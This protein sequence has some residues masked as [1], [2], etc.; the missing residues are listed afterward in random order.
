MKTILYKISAALVVL[1]LITASCKDL[2]EM[3]INPNGVDPAIAHPNLLIATVI[4][5]SGQNVVALGFGDMAGVMQHT[6]KDGWGGS[7]DGYEWTDQ[8]WSGY[9]GILRNTEA[10]IKKSKERDL[11]FQRA[12][13]LI[14][15]AYNFGTIADLWGDAPYSKALLGEQGG[16]NLK[17]VFDSQK[18]IYL[19]I[20]ATLDTA[21]TLL[22]KQQ[23]EYKDINP[24][25]DVM[26]NGD[27]RQWQKFANSI[28]LRYYLR[29]SSKEPALAQA[30]IEKIALYPDTY[31]L[32]LDAGDDAA[33]PFIGNSSSDSWPSNTTYDNSESNYRRLKMCSTL[34]NKLKALGD[35][36]LAVWA[37]KIDIPIVVDPGQASG[38]DEIVN[39]KRIIAQDVADFYSTKYT[40]V[41]APA[42]TIPVDQSTDYVGMPPSWSLLPQAFNLC[43]DLQQAPYNPHCSH[44][45]S[46]YKNSAGPLLKA[47]MLSAAEVNFDLAEA[48]LKGW[49]AGG[50]AQAYYEAGVKAS[51][52]AWGLGDSYDSYIANGG[53]AYD[54]TLAQI[55]EQKW[56]ASWTSAAEAWF[57]YRRTGLPDL[58]PGRV[59][60][61]AAIPLR[62]YYGV[63]EMNFNPDNA[64]SA[65]NKLEA[66]DFSSSDG[67]NSAWSKMWLMQGTDKPW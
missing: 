3:N 11:D 36:R 18:D 37:S 31:P 30:G 46:I 19:G 17:P 1:T 53:V 55:M 12:I 67:K 14:F 35:P 43:P 64:Q 26:Y 57:D 34:V 28:A 50:S 33:F 39:G 63:N 20:L 9:Y 5:F 16:A 62:F 2:T 29:I 21:N 56:I 48:A 24:T 47:R 60:K 41:P 44:L 42:D 51:L 59:V 22:S 4:T 10:L 27:V 8:D 49:S 6:Q 40:T 7:H 61:R 13:G 25:Q 66:T 38:Y 45:N 15:K 52:E 23:S 58:K 65:I 32:I 54:G